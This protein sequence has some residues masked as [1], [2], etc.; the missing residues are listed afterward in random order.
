MK[1]LFL[2]LFLLFGCYDN[3]EYEEKCYSGEKEGCILY[4][5]LCRDIDIEIKYDR[6][7]NGEYAYFTYEDK[8]YYSKESMYNEVCN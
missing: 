3:T 5:G 1:I 2:C 7:C 8:E 6:C 4:N